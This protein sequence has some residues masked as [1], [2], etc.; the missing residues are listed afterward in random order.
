[1][2]NDTVSSPGEGARPIRT[3]ASAAPAWTARQG[4]T[5]AQLKAAER[6]TQAHADRTGAWLRQLG[7]GDEAPQS[8]TEH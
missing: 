2:Q 8:I 5:P 3:E 6:V 1:M 4:L 7:R